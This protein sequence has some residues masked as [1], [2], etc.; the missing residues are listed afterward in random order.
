MQDPLSSIFG[1][2]SKVDIYGGNF[3]FVKGSH[4][5]RTEVQELHISN[6]SNLTDVTIQETHDEGTISE[7]EGIDPGDSKGDD[8]Q[9]SSRKGKKATK[10]GKKTSVPS[11][12]TP[13]YS[14]LTPKA[15]N[16]LKLLMFSVDKDLQKH[17]GN[18]TER[19]F[20]LPLSTFAGVRAARH[21]V[22]PRPL[23]NPANTSSAAN[24][25]EIGISTRVPPESMFSAAFGVP[26]PMNAETYHGTVKEVIQEST[27]VN[28]QSGTVRG[29]NRPSIRIMAD[30]LRALFGSNVDVELNNADIRVVRGTAIEHTNIRETI[31]Q[32][33]GNVRN[34]R[35]NEQNE[36]RIIRDARGKGVTAQHR[37][38]ESNTSDDPDSA[39]SRGAVNA[40]P[41]SSST[42]AYQQQRGVQSRNGASKK[43]N[44]RLDNQIALLEV[45]A[46]R[47]VE[48]SKA[49]RAAIRAQNPPQIEAA[50]SQQS[51]NFSSTNAVVSTHNYGNP[52]LQSGYVYGYPSMPTGIVPGIQNSTT[53]TSTQYAQSSNGAY[54][55]TST[56]TQTSIM[57]NAGAVAT[58][59]PFT[60][61]G[62]PTHSG[63]VNEY[64][65]QRTTTNIKSGRVSNVVYRS[66]TT[67]KRTTD[68][69][70]FD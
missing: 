56:I 57:G 41:S 50:G 36:E 55:S 31:F 54:Q 49:E 6:S 7:G 25:N 40:Q 66:T 5:E 69:S 3:T 17:H 45:L 64:I 33:V 59:P 19:P 10:P 58:R 14:G 67:D 43:G 46:G 1:S 8:H 63:H 4:T 37:R 35:I 20:S 26:G 70:S 18:Q 68:T 60:V 34:A 32:N 61:S 38:S 22:P 21:G 15:D 28:V 30:S 23:G 24:A 53:S 16:L 11:S 48:K 12:E 52:G 13:P 27:T 51:T 29:A 9:R 2:G 42:L 62:I 47:S 65:E 44:S 39:E